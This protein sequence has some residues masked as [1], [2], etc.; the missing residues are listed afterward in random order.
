MSTFLAAES[1][2]SLAATVTSDQHVESVLRNIV[3]GL[4]SQPSV[5]LTR[6][7]LLPSADFPVPPEAPS[8]SAVRAGYLRLAAS[9]GTPTDSPG[10]DWS[11]LQGH[12]SRMSFNV[13]KVGEVAANRSPILI[14]DVASQNEWIVRPE[15]AKREEIRSFAGHPLIFRDE[16]LGVIGVFSRKPLVEQEFAWLGLFAN[17]AAIAIANARAF[18]NVHKLERQ[19]RQIVDAIPQMIAVL[20]PNGTVLYANQTSLDYTGLTIKELMGG[21]FRDRAFHAEDV[22]RLRTE[23]LKALSYGRPFE[24]E[25]RVLGKDGQYRWFLMQYNPVIG[26]DGRVTRWYATATDIEDRKQTEERMRNEN[27]ALREQIDRDS[28]FEDIVGSSASLRIVLKQVSKVAPSDSTILILGETG[29][30]KE[31]VARAIHKRSKRAERAFIAVNCAAI[32]PSLIASEL[33]GHEKGAF[34]GATQRRL[35]RFEAAS[36]GTIFLDEV[37]DLPQEVQIALLRVLQEREVERVGSAKPI[38]VDVR[39]LAA[40]HRDLEKLASEGEVRQDLLY[41]LNVVPIRMPSLR[42]RAA[43][44]PLLAGYFINRFG[45]KFGKKFRAIDKKSLQLL[46]AYDWPGNV[47]EL[48]NVIERAVTLSDSDTFAVDATWLKR[49][50][51]EGVPSTA[52]NGVLLKQEKAMIEAA[53]AE[54]RGRVSGPAGAAAKLR[55]PTKTLDSKIKRMGIDK[56]RFK[57]QID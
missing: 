42:E 37:G 4:A 54:S 3:Q 10:E 27:L 26:E 9:A 56:Y 21:G 22:A 18:E 43:D 41:R 36:G 45:N 57:S 34:T 14:K 15:W 16:L 29:T 44:I 24:N 31:L 20:N 46:Q 30:G 6:I 32:S 50:P 8:D 5:A 12:F 52:L 51:S 13:G 53:L 49:T 33:F 35:G 55:I 11:F 2:L 1:L 39:I 38:P 17:Q 23:R 25:Q 28:M 48:Q 47:R 40:T 19:L 7:W